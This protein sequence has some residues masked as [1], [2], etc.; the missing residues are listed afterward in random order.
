MN[1]RKVLYYKSYFIDFFLSLD[2]KAQKKMAYVIDMLKTRDRISAK[3]VKHIR[4]GIY[5][6]RAMSEGN[7]YRAFFIFDN[8]NIIVLFNGFHKKTQK[9]PEGEIRKAIELKYEYYA[10]KQ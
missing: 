5:E 8:G 9:T 1:E 2:A 7:I 10:G 6:M 4:E 3:F